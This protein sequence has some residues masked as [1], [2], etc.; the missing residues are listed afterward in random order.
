[1][2][3][4]QPILAF[5]PL[6]LLPP[7]SYLLP[8]HPHHRLML[9]AVFLTSCF[10]FSLT[11]SGLFNEM[12]GVSKPGSLNFYTLFRLIPLT[13][14]VSRNLTLIYPTL[15]GSLDPLLCD[16]IAA[17][18]GLIF[19]LLMPHTLAAASSFSSSGAY[20]SLNFLLPLFLRLTPILIM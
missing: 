19:F 18:P 9:L 1:M 11:P 5:K 6:I 14:F 17:T 20:S 4:S 2:K 8:L 10:L 16:L 3:H 12:L 15:S 7:T 13:P